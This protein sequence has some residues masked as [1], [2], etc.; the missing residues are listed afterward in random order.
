MRRR[1]LPM[2]RTAEANAFRVA[3]AWVL[4]LSL[5]FLSVTSSSV[6]AAGPRLA[7]TSPA[8]GAFVGNGSAVIVVF[9]V[10]NFVLVQ[11]GR[12][13]Q[14]VGPAE[15]HVN[16]YVDG[17]YTWMATRVEPIVLPVPS[18]SHTI[19]MQLVANDGSPLIPDVSASIRVVA[20]HGP[21]GGIPTLAIVSPVL[22]QVTG[23]D[24]YVSVQVTNFTFV[25]P[26][27]Q[28]NAPN[29]G[30]WEL[31]LGTVLRQELSRYDTG[32]MVDLP[33]G[34]NTITARLVNNDHTPLSPN[35]TASVT[36]RVKGVTV[37]VLNEEMSGGVAL[38]LAAIL[39]VMIFRRRKARVRIANEK[40]EKP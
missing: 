33:D 34:N 2:G 19:R 1:L 6:A 30:H 24:V 11:P 23:H 25:D 17:S 3:V 9:N 38:L 21:A 36:I 15:G 8:D 10:S 16:V 35:V 20:T 39:A 14:G 31:Y 22:N 40:R 18:G 13:G 32:F 29:E 7:I 27:G 5:L 12:V 37:S 28:P 26:H 4:L